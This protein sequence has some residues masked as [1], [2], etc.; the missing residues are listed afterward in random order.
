MESP[1]HEDPQDVGPL[2][3]L[4]CA[5][6]FGVSGLVSRLPSRALHENLESVFLRASSNISVNTYLELVDPLVLV[7]LA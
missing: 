1:P 5:Q 4:P 3:F 7:P 2:L 6:S